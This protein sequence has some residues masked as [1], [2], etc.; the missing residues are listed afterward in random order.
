MPAKQLKKPVRK[1]GSITRS[2]SGWEEVKAL[3][4]AGECDSENN[5]TMWGGKVGP[6]ATRGPEGSKR[7]GLRRFDIPSLVHAPK[8]CD[9]QTHPRGN[10]WYAG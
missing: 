1:A 4:V 5:P 9:E 3:F 7:A 10:E 8:G 2:T 6:D